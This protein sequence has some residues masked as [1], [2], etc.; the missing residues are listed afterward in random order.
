MNNHREIIENLYRRYTDPSNSDLMEMIEG[1]L[2]ILGERLNRSDTHFVAELIQNAEDAGLRWHNPRV[3]LH[4]LIEPKRIVAQNDARPFDEE[5][6]KA[7]C[8]AAASSKRHA[9]NQ[10]GFMG[11]GFK[12]VF[13]ITE[14]PEIY[15]NGFHFRIKRY[16]YPEWVD[17]PLT[18][19]AANMQNA[20]VI[21]FKADL[22]TEQ[23]AQEFDN[24]DPTLL[25]FLQRLKCI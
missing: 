24:L 17:T 10:I 12:S 2:Q 22:E 5:D 9:E 16:I 1:M 8:R 11:I 7:I 3:T 19:P 6:T 20:F 21:P 14:A 23:L 4:F 15:S 13:K 18:L 25:L